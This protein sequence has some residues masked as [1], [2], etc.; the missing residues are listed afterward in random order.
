MPPLSMPRSLHS[1]LS[2]H[3]LSEENSAHSRN[4]DNRASNG[5]ALERKG[6]EEGQFCRSSPLRHFE[7]HCLRVCKGSTNEALGAL[8]EEMPF[9]DFEV[10][11]SIDGED[12]NN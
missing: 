6:T 5:A 11:K 2:T 7:I 1:L 10:G 12:E 8:V 9:N 3:R 4:I